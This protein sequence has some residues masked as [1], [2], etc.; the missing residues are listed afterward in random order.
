MIQIKKL[1]I[2]HKTDLR[3][4][5]NDFKMVLNDGDKAVIIGEEGNGKSTI[6]KWIYSPKLIDSYA[7]YSGERILGNEILAYL[8]QEVSEEDKNK[9][10][11]EFFCDD[12]RF[13]DLSPKELNYL[14]TQVKFDLEMFY[15]DQMVGSLS[16]GEKIKIQMIRIL[17]HKP[18][19]LLLD[20]PTNDIDIETLEWLEKFINEWKH[21]VL[22]VSHDETLIEKTANM[23]IHIEQIQ[24][25]TISRYNIAHTDYQNYLNNK[26]HEFEKQNQ[27][28]LNERREK[29]IRDEKMMRMMQSVDYAQDGISRSNPAGGR[30]LAKKMH[31]IKSLQKRYEREDENM[32][33]KPQQ[34]EAI[35]IKIGSTKDSEVPNGKVILDYENPILMTPNNERVLSEN[36]KLFIKGPEKIC[37]IGKNGAGKTTLLHLIADEMLKRKDI[38]VEYMSQNYEEILDLDCTPV[39]Y[40]DS[41]GDKE[42]RT[43]IR[44]YLGA[45]KYTADEMDHSIRELSGG[46]KAKVL[47]LKI[48]LSKAN[49]LILDEPTRNF[50]PLS[51]PVLRRVLSNFPG[52]IISISHDRKYIKEV[53]NKVYKLDK[54]GLIKLD[55]NV[56]D[57]L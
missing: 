1:E 50:S 29:K 44:T 20:E 25:K 31:S 41:S 53:C 43:R 47:L 2:I 8:P 27:E 12:E 14:A 24:R 11:Y 23:I 9:T 15:S 37:I 51:G 38:T 28:A 3:T 36:V 4:I 33:E 22:Y 35:F 5:I 16:G 57:K 6:L 30:L 48:S 32:T 19:V 34:E 56:I 46:Q 21:I 7:D 45:M 55:D 17:M 10:V 49:V 39:D 13:L 18:S 52:S 26:R 42:E 40:L 54:D